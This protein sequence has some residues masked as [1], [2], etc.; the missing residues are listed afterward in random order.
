M[1]RRRYA[2]NAIDEEEMRCV[3]NRQRMRKRE[4]ERTAVVADMPMIYND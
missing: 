1:E 2:R 4:R 3:R